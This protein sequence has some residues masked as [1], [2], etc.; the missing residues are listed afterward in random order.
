MIK[1]KSDRRFLLYSCLL[2]VVLVTGLA[3]RLSSVR[4]AIAASSR[5]YY[6]T[7]GELATIKQKAQVGTQPY[8]DA[9]NKVLAF[10]TSDPNYWP[11]G[12]ISGAQTCS[13]TLEPSFLGNGAPL[14]YAKALAYHLT[15]DQRFAAS[16]REKLLDLIDATSYNGEVYSG[17]NQ[18]ILNL[19]W[20]LPAWIQTADLLESYAGWSVE[21]KMM[22]QRWLAAEAFKK[23]EWNSDSR[24]NNWGVAGSA[25]TAMI[26]DYL[27]G[28]QIAL[29]DRNNKQLTNKE[30][31]D[32]AKQHQV[33]RL[34][35][36]SYMDNYVCRMPGVGI[37]PDGGIP[38]ELGRGSTGCNGL[39]LQEQDNSYVYMQSYHQGMATHAELL[40]RR[41]DKS[42]YDNLN[43]NG[44]GNILK[45][46]LFVSANPNDPSKSYD[47][48]ATQKS[49]LEIYYRY[50]R[51]TEI[52]KRLG[53]GGARFIAGKGIQTIH[54]ATLTHGFA[55]N[56]DPG[57]PPV[58]APPGSSTPPPS[59]ATPNI[60]LTKTVSRTRA[61][62]GD[63][64]S[65]TITYTNSGTGEA[66]NLRLTD[67][68]PAGTTYVADSAN[69]EATFL[70]G[71]LTWT[72]Q[73]LA[74]GQSGSVLFK[75]KVN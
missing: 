59:T 29:A 61:N 38:E 62:V 45:A 39:A 75:V 48:L 35:G 32:E 63:T 22:F 30:I 25:S 74:P 71:I 49:I 43:G 12:T 69:A 2:I 28:S 47:W 15:D 46:F 4:P 7:P 37:R 50:Y 52:A 11:F 51:N 58:T 3:T 65:F 56:E 23:V 21:D 54:F 14:V 57:P 1:E 60:S 72:I 33:D 8:K 17:G 55:I 53:I 64:L 13:A 44:A 9:V 6:T 19:S 20:Y 24:S 73:S 18:C 31:W 26:A 16:V 42:L 66:V 27:D 41:G 34:N 10:A 68:I 5:G 36:N 40:L 67:S 70:N